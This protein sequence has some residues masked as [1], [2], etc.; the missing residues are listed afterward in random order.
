MSKLTLI[1]CFLF[2]CVF[3][4]FSFLSS[5]M[6][7]GVKF[8]MTKEEVLDKIKK[9]YDI[10]KVEENKIEALNNGE[11]KNFY[12]KLSFWFRDDSLCGVTQ[13]KVGHFK[14]GDQNACLRKER[15]RR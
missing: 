6:P 9:K 1:F 2:I 15:M 7:K 8:G 11:R 5:I 13:G 12:R 14:N 4:G 10:Q 3:C